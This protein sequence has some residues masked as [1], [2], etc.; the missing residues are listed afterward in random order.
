MLSYFVKDTLY[1]ILF[2]SVVKSILVFR[3]NVLCVGL[4]S[5]FT[6]MPR[7]DIHRTMQISTLLANVF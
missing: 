1:K 5:M 3:T 4:R 2:Y 7:K 6:V